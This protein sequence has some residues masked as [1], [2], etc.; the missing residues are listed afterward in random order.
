MGFQKG[1]KVR[2]GLEPWSKGLTKETDERLSNLSNKMIIKKKEYYKTH[3]VWNKMFD[4]EKTAEVKK[5][6]QEGVPEKDIA[7][8]FNCDY[9]TIWRMVKDLRVNK[10]EKQIQEFKGRLNAL[11]DYERG[12]I[13]GMLDGEGCILI[14]KVT[15]SKKAY[16]GYAT[17]VNISNQEKDILQFIYKKLSLWTKLTC[18]KKDRCYGIN[19]Y[20][21]DMISEFLKFIKPYSHSRKTKK[22]VEILLKF[23]NAKNRTEQD[24]IYQEFKLINSKIL[25]V[26]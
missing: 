12:Y 7:I 6:F 26:N 5:L 24:K 21:K 8:K 10:R 15:T 23:C 9:S 16:E 25:N 2:V 13:A 3:E 18:G 17:I 11:S 1:N 4:E 14:H 19:I 20:G 22:K